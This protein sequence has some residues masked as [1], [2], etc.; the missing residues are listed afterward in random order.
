MR[1]HGLLQRMLLIYDTAAMR[2]QGGS[3][4]D[5]SYIY[6]TATI[7]KNF[8]E[9]Y[10]EKLEKDYLF[11][12][13]KKAQLLTVLVD[14]LRR[15]HSGGRSVTSEI[16]RLSQKQKSISADER[17]KLISLMHSFNRMYRPHEARED[18]ILF[19]A[20]KEVVSSNEYDALGEDFERKE[21]EKFGKGGFDDMVG[22]VADIEKEIGIYDLDQFTPGV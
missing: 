8:V 10:H 7:V 15:Q 22:K 19:P 2:W 12:R 17:D 11:P 3:D 14:T 5:P 9:D 21:H 18:T 6:Q 16:L 1:E 4:F 13:L 20:F